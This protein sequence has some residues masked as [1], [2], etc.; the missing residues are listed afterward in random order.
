M[1][2]SQVKIISGILAFSWMAF[3]IAGQRRNNPF[4]G[5]DQPI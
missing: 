2:I 3:D 1:D 5:Q 4:E